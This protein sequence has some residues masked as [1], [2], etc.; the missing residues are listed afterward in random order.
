MTTAIINEAAPAPLLAFI[1][2]IIVLIELEELRVDDE[3]I[4]DDA[5]ADCLD[6]ALSDFDNKLS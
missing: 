2:D 1:D 4:D 5:A 3:F 6:A